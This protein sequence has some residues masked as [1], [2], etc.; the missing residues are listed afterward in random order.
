MIL[1]PEIRSISDM[2][3]TGCFFGNQV[4]FP[5][6][7]ITIAISIC[8][9]FWHRASEWGG[10]SEFLLRGDGNAVNSFS[11]AGDRLSATGD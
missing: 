4:S 6:F 11:T 3:V 5:I 1:L 7:L 10:E 8:R 9:Y 2:A